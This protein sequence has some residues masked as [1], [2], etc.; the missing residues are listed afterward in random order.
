MHNSYG[1]NGN[2]GTKP[3]GSYGI[4]LLGT[5]GTLFIDRAGYE[6]IP[7]MTGHSEKI[8]QSFREAFDDLTGS[9][10]YFSS[11][12]G[13]E[14]G[15]TSLQHMPHVRNFLDCMKSRQLPI[16]DIEI[17]HRST[18]PC[19]LGNI[20]CRTGEK[21]LWD[22]KAERITNNAKA[23]AMLTRKY[24]EPWKLVGMEG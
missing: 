10:M 21:I 11:E 8:S 17:G 2:P 20:A 19:H 18:V 24:R 14:R 9:G 7:Q 22:A 16:G 3:F 5:R 23:N 6:I 4:L 1:H 12:M 15:T 13:G